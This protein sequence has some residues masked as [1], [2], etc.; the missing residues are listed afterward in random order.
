M[1][2]PTVYVVYYSTYGHVKTLAN[3]IMEGLNKSGTVNAKLFQFQETLSDEILGKMHAPKKDEAVPVI[4]LADLTDAD[5]FLFGFPTRYGNA[6]AQV[7]AFW[8]STGQLW[9][10][11]ALQGKMAGVFFSTASQGGGQETTAL[12]FLPNLVHHGMIYVPLGYTHANLFALDEVVGGS[13]YGSGT[14]AA[15]DGSRQPSEKELTI[16]EHHGE[17]FAKIVAQYHQ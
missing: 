1:A 15:G 7:K 13:A 8:D 4:T 10:S 6:P 2:K 12:T 9:A 3:K 5:A 11:G 16:A 17:R 14:V